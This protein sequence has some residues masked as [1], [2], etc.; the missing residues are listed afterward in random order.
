MSASKRSNSLNESKTNSGGYL[1]KPD[2]GY[3]K[4]CLRCY[5]RYGDQAALAGV[6]RDVEMEFCPKCKSLGR[7]F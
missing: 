1:L 5:D 7:G 6:A 4:L 2:T 3:T